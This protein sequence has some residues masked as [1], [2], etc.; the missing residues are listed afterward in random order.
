GVDK[1]IDF[2]EKLKYSTLSDRSRFGLSMVLGGAEVTPLDHAA[3]YAVFANDG[4][5]HKPVSILKVEDEKGNVLLENKIEDGEQVIDANIAH[6]ISNILSD[7]NARAPFFGAGGYLTLGSRPVAAKT[8]T[9][10]NYKD[11]WT[12]GY[13]PSLVAAVWTGNTDGT[14]MNR[15]SGGSSVAA[16]VWNQ[17]M[18]K[19]LEGTPIETFPT[20]EIPTT[21]KPMLD[22]E[23][24]SET[25]VIDK[26]SGKLATNLTP[27][28]YKE[29]KT[30]GQYHT[31]LQYVNPADPLGNP[32]SEDER[33]PAYQNW[34]TG[35]QNYLK[36][37][38]ENLKEGETPL[39]S[40]EI[41]TEEDDLHIPAN[42]PK[43]KIK[44][45]GNN[46]EVARSFNVEI[47][48]VAKRGVARIEYQIDNITITTNK[49]KNGA[50]ITLPSWVSA[51]KH[52]LT[53]IA[54]DDIDNSNSASINIK[55]KENSDENI[56][57]RITNPFNNQTI[58]LKAGDTYT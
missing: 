4:K 27:D 34:E 14:A 44:S 7:D 10:N 28:S 41:P 21:G 5:Y 1:A 56:S 45:P 24:P 58:E 33:D 31:I 22:G 36:N 23:I 42:K 16:P 43:V 17:F 30:C 32:P 38:N 19:A 26:A 3:A 11:A 51:G 29:E 53:V 55:V 35:V 54:Y 40:C 50:K 6:M 12:V 9:T 20:P 57:G 47:K 39:E 13:T 48:S 2:A 37:Y 18:R 52:Q 8:G 15:G 25:F 49:N 46:D